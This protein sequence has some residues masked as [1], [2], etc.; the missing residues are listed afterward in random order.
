M[1]PLGP[2]SWTVDLAPGECVNLS[3]RVRVTAEGEVDLVNRARADGSETTTVVYVRPAYVARPS[4]SKAC[5][6]A[7]GVGEE[8][9]IL[10]VV[11]NAGNGTFSGE[12]TDRLPDG[13][14]YVPGSSRVGGV[15]AEPRVEG[16]TLIWTV[17]VPPGGSVEIEYSAVTYEPGCNLVRVEGEEDECCVAAS[18]PIITATL[19]LP[20]LG[21]VFPVKKP[22]V[23]DRESAKQVILS[24]G[25][26]KLS[27]TERV[28][29]TRRT[30][31]SL[32]SDPEVAEDAAKLIA[33]G[34]IEVHDITADP[35]I[36][37]AVERVSDSFGADPDSVEAAALGAAIGAK[38]VVL[39]DPEARKVAVSLSLDTRSP[40]EYAEDLA[41]QGRASVRRVLSL[42]R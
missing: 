15:P 29:V 8:I 6:E 22:I 5:P 16:R 7:A 12:V 9:R 11:D 33:L 20:L 19:L 25:A 1:E 39:A 13:W 42:S 30:A 17:E 34:A 41:G 28:H 26:E 27:K 10:I 18:A 31:S 2:T 38:Y 40:R 21:L 23:L 24:M 36:R 32:L 3:L 35:G 14:E 37:A 4:V